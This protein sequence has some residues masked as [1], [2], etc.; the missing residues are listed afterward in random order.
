MRNLGGT[1]SSRLPARGAGRNDQAQREAERVLL[2]RYGPACILVDENLDILYFH[3]ETSPLSRTCARTGES[4]SQETRSSELV[5]GI[6]GG[7]P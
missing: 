4:Q 3:G 2:A 7:D 1:K 6:V 5:G